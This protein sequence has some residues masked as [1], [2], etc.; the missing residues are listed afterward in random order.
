VAIIIAEVLRELQDKA[1][2]EDEGEDSSAVDFH[3]LADTSSQ[4]NLGI[5]RGLFRWQNIRWHKPCQ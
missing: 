3:K 5:K 1:E 2:D 4:V